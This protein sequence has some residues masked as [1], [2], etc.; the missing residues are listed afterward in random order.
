VKIKKAI[1][2]ENKQQI[3]QLLEKARMKRENLIKYKYK[4]KELIL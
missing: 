4:K 3:E 2:K 1:Q